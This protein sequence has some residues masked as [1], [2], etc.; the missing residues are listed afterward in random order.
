[1]P[2]PPRLSHSR[3]HTLFPEMQASGPQLLGKASMAL[4]LSQ[5]PTLPQGQGCLFSL[6]KPG[7][8][9]CPLVCRPLPSSLRSQELPAVF[10]QALYLHTEEGAPQPRSPWPPHSSRLVSR[11][12]GTCSHLHLLTGT[13]GA[14]DETLCLLRPGLQRLPEEQSRKR[15]LGASQIL[16]TLGLRWHPL[17]AVVD[18]RE[19]AALWPQS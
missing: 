1:M 8:L 10:R 12:W 15:T 7:S 17:R 14:S 6:G 16:G 13:D 3:P 9:P 2:T 11:C 4:P 5:G 19:K 18:S